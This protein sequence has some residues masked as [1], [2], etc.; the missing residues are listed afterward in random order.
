MEVTVGKKPSKRRWDKPELEDTQ[1]PRTHGR[2]ELEGSGPE[3]LGMFANDPGEELDK[4]SEDVVG[5]KER[6]FEM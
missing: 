3:T 6:V 2:A 5:V 1:L 4:K